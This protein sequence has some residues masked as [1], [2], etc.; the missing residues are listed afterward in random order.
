M[1]GYRQQLLER[2]FDV[3]QKACGKQVKRIQSVLVG[4]VEI[5]DLQQH[6]GKLEAQMEDFT[7]AHAAIYDTLKHEDQRIDQNTRYDSLNR[8][9]QEALRSLN[10]K[11]SALKAAKEDHCSILSSAS[12][13]SRSSKPSRTSGASSSLL[14]KRAEMAVRT[15]RLEAELKFHDVESQKTA[16]L[17]K[18]EDEIKK[19]H[20]MKELAATQAELETVIKIKEET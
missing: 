3:T 18:H 11:I 10:E 16:A 6:R 13:H 12:K 8:G 14:Q 9:N 17:K 2:D 19:L 7:D 15:G 20:K 5:S 1:K 4:K